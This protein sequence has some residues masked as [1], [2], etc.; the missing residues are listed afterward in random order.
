MMTDALAEL[1][2]K[3]NDASVS[4]STTIESGASAPTSTW[5]HTPGP[6]FAKHSKHDAWII[7]LSP[8]DARGDLANLLMGL[9]ARF[10]GEVAANAR[11]IAA[12]PDLL[13]ELTLAVERYDPAACDSEFDAARVA[14]AKATGALS[15]G[16]LE[17]R[18]HPLPKG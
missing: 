14:I 4:P 16:A 11:L 3:S 13:A 15:D 5:A 7:T 9:G 2:A 18:N 6:W 10:I 8:E 1:K 17:R 12:A